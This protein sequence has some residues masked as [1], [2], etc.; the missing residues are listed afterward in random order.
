MAEVKSIP[1][2]KDTERLFTLIAKAERDIAKL[3]MYREK[4]R[5]KFEAIRAQI[6]KYRDELRMVGSD[7]IKKS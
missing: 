2:N 3:N 4:D 7:A 1:G 6:N 5:P